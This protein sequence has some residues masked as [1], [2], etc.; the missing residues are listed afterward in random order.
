M[1]ISETAKQECIARLR[2]WLRPGDTIHTVL[3]HCS[4]S[5]MFRRI[6]LLK[7][8]KDGR[9]INLDYSA[10]TAMDYNLR[11]RQEGIPV[12]GCGMDMGFHLVYSLSQVLFPK[13]FTC[14]GHKC[15]SNDHSNGDRNY[16]R[17]HHNSG[18]YALR[19]Q[20]M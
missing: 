13:G 19:H 17:H 8:E 2:E 20:W 1:K 10:A 18:G 14:I 7:P 15:P 11:D 9:I 3:R 6:S 16:R 5:G 4:R 12:S